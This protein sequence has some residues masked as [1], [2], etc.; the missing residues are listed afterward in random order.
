MEIDTGM[1]IID[2]AIQACQGHTFLYKYISANDVGKTG[3]HQ[4]GFYMPYCCWPLIFNSPGEKGTNM[5]RFVCISWNDIHETMSRFI[6]YGTG[7]RREYRLTRLGRGFPF[8]TDDHIGSLM[9]IVKDVEDRY[10][11]FVLDA[12]EDID[13]F[14]SRFNISPFE[15]CGLIKPE[16]TE[17]SD[18][19]LVTRME[20]FRE[21]VSTIP[22]D[23]P[24]TSDISAAAREFCRREGQPSDPDSRII[25]WLDMEFS[26]FKYIEESR[27]SGFIHSGFESIEEFLDFAN[28]VLNRR[29]SRAGKS[30]ELHLGAMFHDYSIPFTN[31]GV[32]EKNKKPDFIFPSIDQYHNLSFPEDS[33]IFLAAKT[34]CKDRWRQIL[35]EAGRIDTKHLFTLQPGISSN[36]MEEMKDE[37]VILVI[38]KSNLG[39]FPKKYQEDILTLNSFIIYAK[40]KV[41]M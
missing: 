36:Q 8:M 18:Y 26:L 21:Y 23:F 41:G 11:A 14:V 10:Q 32:T 12:D 28:T 27:Y 39:Y 29:K 16:S 3:S 13:Q 40:N 7:T 4:S 38:P 6:W 34:T 25:L 22:D 33:L 17:I 5:D 1:H 19:P 30:L 37:S 9:V 35:N 20:M 2:K 24:S 15:P 31:N